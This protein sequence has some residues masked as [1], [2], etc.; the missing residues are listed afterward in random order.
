MLR[1]GDKIKV[2]E[3]LVI[4]NKYEGILFSKYMKNLKGKTVTIK[5]ISKRFDNVSTYFIEESS[6]T[7]TKSMFDFTSTCNF[8]EIRKGVRIMATPDPY[9]E[10]LFSI[11]PTAR[12]SSNVSFDNV[13]ENY[14]D[15][16]LI[17]IYKEG[18]LISL[19]AEEI[20]LAKEYLT[21]VDNYIQSYE[22]PKQMTKEEVEKVLGYKIELI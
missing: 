5:N 7:L 21:K 12:V 17:K 3:D 4:D 10:T 2:R 20:H 15:I 11:R 1:I 16:P 9:I 13:L 14:T 6:F 22:K 19:N 8:D 18:S